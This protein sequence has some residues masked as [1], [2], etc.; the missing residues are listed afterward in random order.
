MKAS[1]EL[2]AVQV[3]LSFSRGDDTLNDGPPADDS[4]SHSTSPSAACRLDTNNDR[5]LIEFS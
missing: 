4:A 5:N 2:V 3:D 1:D